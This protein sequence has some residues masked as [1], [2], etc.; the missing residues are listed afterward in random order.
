MPRTPQLHGGKQTRLAN[1]HPIALVPLLISPLSCLDI[2]KL[3]R[4]KLLDRP[5]FPGPQLSSSPRVHQLDER[6]DRTKSQ[7]P[8]ARAVFAPHPPAPHDH[9]TKR[10]PAL[11]T[12]G[13]SWSLQGGLKTKGPRPPPVAANRQLCHVAGTKRDSRKPRGELKMNPRMGDDAG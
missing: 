13:P 12:G 10:R 9:E 7:S 3:D 6:Q 1:P 2:T 5:L 8:H 4:L 11:E